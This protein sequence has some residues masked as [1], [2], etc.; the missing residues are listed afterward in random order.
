MNEKVKRILVIALYVLV[1]LPLTAQTVSNARFVQEGNT[2]RI[3]YDL[4]KQTDIKIEFSM[5]GGGFYENLEG[6]HVTG[7][8]GRAIEPGVDK[9]VIWD[10]LKD[11]IDFKSERVCF[12]VT[13]FE[14]SR[15]SF[16]VGDISFDMVFVEGGKFTMGCAGQSDCRDEERPAHKVSLDDYYIG[17]CEVTQ[18]LWDAVMGVERNYSHVN[19]EKLPV[20]G[21]TWIDAQE[22]VLR[23][24]QLLGE[25]GFRLPTEAQWEYA[26]RGGKKDRG[27]MYSGGSDLGWVAWYVDNSLGQPHQVKQKN[28]NALGVYDM[29]GNVWE[30]CEDWYGDYETGTHKNPQ[31]P[32][33]G[34]TRVLRGGSWHE[35][36]TFCRV[37]SRYCKAPSFR[38]MNIGF[39]L[40]YELL[41]KK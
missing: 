20:D 16:T 24:N 39:R 10:V 31:G 11:R 29:N 4:T 21:V 12:R 17:E 26:A 6:K 40:V 37:N 27:F 1:V 7:D 22:F 9:C 35:T 13:A 28:P 18:E 5:D 33:D 34:V 23:L 2:I 15:R 38:G 32:E 30:W 41:K 14:F 19:G 36:P 3:C 8:I 25:T